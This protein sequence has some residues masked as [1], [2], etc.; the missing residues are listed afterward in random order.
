[1]KKVTRQADYAKWSKDFLD[2]GLSGS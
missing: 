2:G 1:M